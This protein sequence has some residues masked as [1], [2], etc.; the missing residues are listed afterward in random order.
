MNVLCISDGLAAVPDFIKQY[1]RSNNHKVGFLGTAA[2]VQ[3]N[4]AEDKKFFADN[5][6]ITFDIHLDA[7]SPEA[8]EGMVNSMPALYVAGGN[9]FY[10]LQELKIHGFDIILRKAIDDGLAYIGASAGCAILAPSIE[11][12]SSM[13]DPGLAPKLQSF[14]AIDA[15]DFYP[16][17]HDDD[18]SHD[19]YNKIEENYPNEMFVRFN[20]DQ[21]LIVTERDTFELVDSIR[22]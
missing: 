13:D 18:E 21:A 19:R 16:L 17:P 3:G 4:V 6:I 14:D 11:Y 20:D 1:G 12:V 8:F 10:L 15:L 9:T 2:D 7:L 5:K 22:L